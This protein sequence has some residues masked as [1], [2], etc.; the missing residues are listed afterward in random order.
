MAEIVTMGIYCSRG[1]CLTSNQAI[2][3]FSMLVPRLDAKN[4]FRGDLLDSPCDAGFPNWI[5]ISDQAVESKDHYTSSVWRVILFY[6][7]W[8]LWKE[9]YGIREGAG[10]YPS[11][12]PDQLN[13]FW[14]SMGC[15]I[16]T[17]VIGFQIT[18]M[19]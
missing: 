19:I 1:R 2:C 6:R 7:L 14:R 18:L 16:L 13:Q 10:G 3:P 12:Q 11:S 15:Q 17:Q 8:S 5:V 9:T 4:P